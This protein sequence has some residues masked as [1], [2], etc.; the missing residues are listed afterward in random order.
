[1]P[2][3]NVDDIKPASEAVQA[4][5]HDMWKANEEITALESKYPRD[6]IQIAKWEKAKGDARQRYELALIELDR[7]T[8]K[9]IA[10]AESE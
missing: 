9:L 2:T 7:T 6:V 4:A 8:R 1:M 10:R 5:Q 3:I